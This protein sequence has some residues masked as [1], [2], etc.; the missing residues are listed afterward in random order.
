MTH[1]E[2]AHREMRVI[3]EKYEA[4]YNFAYEH[5]DEFVQ[6]YGLRTCLIVLDQQVL[7]AV[8]PEGDVS[9]A[10]EELQLK[11]DDRKRLYTRYLGAPWI[12]PTANAS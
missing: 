7:F 4:D 11:E 2:R 5:E 9:R 10:I 12:I 3:L 6:K 8:K 1:G